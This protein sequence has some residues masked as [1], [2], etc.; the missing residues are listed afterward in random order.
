ML[1]ICVNF[2]SSSVCVCMYTCVCVFV[3]VC[4]C[5]MSVGMF[6]S[7]YIIFDHS[8]MVYS[9]FTLHC[10]YRSKTVLENT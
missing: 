1:G 3:F 9:S 8:I 5:Y 10:M 7:G 6:I 4:V 2:K